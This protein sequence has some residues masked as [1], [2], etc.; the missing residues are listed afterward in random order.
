MT[1][2]GLGLVNF[3]YNLQNYLVPSPRT[4]EIGHILAFDFQNTYSEPK[5]LELN[6]HLTLLYMFDE[7]A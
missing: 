6:V 2:A 5:Y 3:Q 1:G 4:L 7:I